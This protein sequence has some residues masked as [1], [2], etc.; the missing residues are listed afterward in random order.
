MKVD[1]AGHDAKNTG[2]DPC[3]VSL[4][5][6]S[7]HVKKLS[8][9]TRSRSASTKIS[10]DT[11]L[12]GNVFDAICEVCFV[13]MKKELLETLSIKANVGPLCINTDQS[14]SFGSVLS[15]WRFK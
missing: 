9:E 5:Y 14:P 8:F 6:Y 15:R 1:E 10:P 4:L 13:G 2:T 11:D 7:N 3:F 12:R